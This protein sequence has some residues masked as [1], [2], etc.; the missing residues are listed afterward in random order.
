MFK[1]RTLFVVGAGASHE[2]GLPIGVKLADAIAR[3][4][5]FKRDNSGFDNY[6]GGD[7]LLLEQMRRV[8]KGDQ[9]YFPA[10]RVI[11]DGVRLSYSID[12]F[13][14]IHQK[15]H[16]TNLIGK[17]AIVRAILQAE[18]S[19]QLYFD[20]SNAYN[21]LDMVHAEDTWIIKFVRML[22]R[23]RR[24]EEIASVFDNVSFIVFN[25]DR[26]IEHFLIQA[27]RQLYAIRHDQA[28][29][30]VSKLDI[31]HPYGDVG[32]LHHGVPFGGGV[33]ADN[34]DCFELAKRIRTYT[35]V[36]QDEAKENIDIALQDAAA[37]VFLGFGYHEQNLRLL[38]PGPNGH[39]PKHI[40]GTA[41]KMSEPDL[42]VTSKRLALFFQA[43]NRVAMKKEWPHLR[44]DLTCA[45]LFDQYTQSLPA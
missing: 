34:I 10:A 27:L 24:I 4:L 44:S 33:D 39:D 9:A 41:H 36:K 20:Q 35:E 23:N 25:Y 30:L 11:A 42:K 19:S 1:K 13:L 37:W 6:S 8:A 45:T 28:A 38:M 29:E 43:D 5:D 12:D 3:M 32:S 16:H 26:C 2:F 22:G 17:A 7:G 21:K 31:I 18:R 15:N 14:D 40:F